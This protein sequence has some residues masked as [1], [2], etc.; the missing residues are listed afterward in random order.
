MTLRTIVLMWKLRL[1]Y[2]FGA[3]PDKLARMYY[4]RGN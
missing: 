2:F 1:L 4:R 3:E